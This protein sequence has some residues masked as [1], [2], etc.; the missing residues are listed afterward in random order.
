MNYRVV[1]G[2][3]KYIALAKKES[4][5]RKNPWPVHLEPGELWFEIDD[6]PEKALAKLK[7]SLTKHEADR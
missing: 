3:D 4:F 5:V 6:T 7:E 1:K 2:K